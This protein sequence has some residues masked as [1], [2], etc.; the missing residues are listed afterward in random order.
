MA[1]LSWGHRSGIP[2]FPNETP[3]EYGL[4]LNYHFPAL[5]REIGLIIDAFNREVYG[6]NH[7]Q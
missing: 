5:K 6:R 1:L 2:H 4:R 7:S 3:K